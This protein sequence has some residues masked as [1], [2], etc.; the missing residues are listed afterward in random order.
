MK[1]SLFYLSLFF[2]SFSAFSQKNSNPIVMEING[3]GVTKSEFLQIYLKN[4]NDP[5]F[6]KASID[7]YLELFKKFKLK[8]AEAEALGY[9]TIPKLKKELDGYKK[10]LAN[11]YLIDSAQNEALVREAYN[12]I[13]NEIRASHVLIRVDQNAK[14]Q[15]TLIAWNKINEIKKRLEKGED[16]ETVAKSKNGSEDPSVVNNGGDLG[17]FTAFQ[18]IYPFEDRAFKTAIG[19][20][21]EIFRTRFGYHILKTTGERPSRGSIKVAHLLVSAGKSSTDSEKANAEKKAKEIKAKLAAGEKWEE[22]VKMYSDDPSS[23][24]KGGEL[25]MF[26]SG[27]NQ[28]MIPAFE[29]AAFA[30]KADGDISEPVQTDFGF[31]I[32]KRIEWK[33]VRPYN[34]MKKE[35]QSKVNKDDRAK[36]TQDSFVEK[37]KKAYNY[38]LP[39]ANGL[40]WFVEN[41]DTTFY[42]GKWKADKLTTDLEV[43]NL[44]G[45]S[46]T[47]KQFASYLEKSYRGIKKE[48]NKKVVESVFKNWVKATIL[49]YEESKLETKYP[50]YKALVK[51]YHDGILL[52]EVMSDKVWNK[53]IKDTTGLK[54]Y[55]EA[56]RSNYKW[57]L[58]FDATVYECN[59]AKNA[60][61][62]YK[63]L[64]KKKNTSKEI[65]EKVNKQSELNLRVKMNKFDPEQTAYLKGK[66]LI[67]GRNKPYEFEGKYYVVFVN[68]VLPIMNKELSEAKGPVTS[69]YQ[70]YLEKTWLE[71]LSKKHQITLNYD[72]LYSL[73][74]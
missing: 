40:D 64:K 4:N 10:Q 57:P 16:F 46:Y 73:D 67:D 71:E 1:K 27:T 5:K 39:K 34:E 38:K 45:K 41:L 32:I 28:R 15:D 18:M 35:I 26:G 21:S 66:T 59:N 58:R 74:K 49:E 31:H 25:P 70:N 33:P 44:D 7:E 24:Q 47:Q 50:D 61:I 55:F 51:E 56:N 69:D 52:Y 23:N 54:N 22:L 72:V 63:M 3:K 30:L 9:D 6:D 12:R 13:A 65:I 19:N 43:F 53:A 17:F 48:D 68:Q 42:L 11:P 20:T 8:V 62:A 37:L 60:E 2:V 29:E 14:P 36:T